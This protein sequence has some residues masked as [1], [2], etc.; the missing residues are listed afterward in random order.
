MAQLNTS[1]SIKMTHQFHLRS[2]SAILLTG[3]A[4]VKLFH[5]KKFVNFFSAQNLFRAW[6]SQSK[7]WISF[8]LSSS[9]LSLSQKHRNGSK[10]PDLKLNPKSEFL[11]P[12]LPHASVSLSLSETELDLKLGFKPRR[13]L[14]EKGM[15]YSPY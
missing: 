15:N 10:Q 13:I 9:R 12:S 7:I 1:T 8:P 2:T 4:S 3:G 14:A 6:I 11:F 5:L